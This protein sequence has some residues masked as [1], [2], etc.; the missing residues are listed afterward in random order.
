VDHILADPVFPILLELYRCVELS[1]FKGPEG[2]YEACAAY[3]TWRKNSGNP[4][5]DRDGR[6]QTRKNKS[7]ER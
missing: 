7:S 6:K 5:R 2:Y 3:R 4:Y 1:T